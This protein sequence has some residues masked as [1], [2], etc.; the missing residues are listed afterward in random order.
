MNFEFSYSD[1][2]GVVEEPS[3]PKS[4]TFNYK[5]ENAKEEWEKYIPCVDVLNELLIRDVASDK[6]R[7]KIAIIQHR[8]EHPSIVDDFNNLTTELGLFSKQVGDI[9]YSEY[10]YNYTLYDSNTTLVSQSIEDINSVINGNMSESEL[11]S[12]LGISNCCYERSKNTFDDVQHINQFVECGVESFDCD[13]DIFQC[14]DIEGHT[15]EVFSC[16]VNYGA[17]TIWKYIGIAFLTY[18]PCSWGCDEAVEHAR[19]RYRILYDVYP[20]YASVFINWLDNPV[21]YDSLN[22]IGHI[23]NDYITLILTDDFYWEK[24]IV[25]INGG[26]KTVPWIEYI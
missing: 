12:L 26:I 6:T 15:E 4:L 25:Q 1:K 21:T 14:R 24:R 20:E 23:K 11:A 16:D 8:D 13:S 22:G 3:L 17:L 9:E 18:T 5:Y 19:E 10:L 2:K 7:S